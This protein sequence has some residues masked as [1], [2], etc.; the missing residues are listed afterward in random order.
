MRNLFN[1]K[2][3]YGLAMF[4]F[5][6][7]WSSGFYGGASFS[8]RDTVELK[9]GGQNSLQSN[10]KIN[11][12]NFGFPLGVRFVPQPLPIYLGLEIEPMVGF[13]F[14]DLSRGIED[15]R[16][17]IGGFNTSLDIGILPN[18]SVMVFLRVGSVILI[19]YLKYEVI[20]GGSTQEFSSDVIGAQIGGGVSIGLDGWQGEK[21]GT[22][23]FMILYQTGTYR[24]DFV[25]NHFADDDF[26][27]VQVMVRSTFYFGNF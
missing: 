14:T 13:A 18:D 24:E 6:P 11:D 21:E 3:I 25:S 8:Y 17:V 12:I 10:L 22:I 26:S 16:H 1:L 4:L 19:D 9:E 15:G 7:A 27:A 5:L 20:A 23:D 2:I